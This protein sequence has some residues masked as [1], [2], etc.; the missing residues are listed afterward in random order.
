MKK[1]LV[2]R[3]EGMEDDR[4]CEGAHDD[5][6]EDGE[7]ID[8]KDHGLEGT[9]IAAPKISGKAQAGKM[10]AVVEFLES[11]KPTESVFVI[12]RDSKAKESYF[13]GNLDFQEILNVID[14]EISKFDN[15]ANFSITNG[16]T[17]VAT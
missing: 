3:V 13:G 6:E 10:G 2:V 7:E 12:S 16:P 9:P 8:T 17:L 11:D 14:S 1:C 15:P 4:F 5:Q